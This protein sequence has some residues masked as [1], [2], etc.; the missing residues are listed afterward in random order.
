MSSLER[1]R[2]NLYEVGLASEMQGDMDEFEF[3]DYLAE[4][5]ML[6]I[7]DK[8][9]TVVWYV[10]SDRDCS[11]FAEVKEQDDGTIDF[12]TMHYNGGGSLE[13]VLE[14]YIKRLEEEE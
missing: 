2:G 6:H 10:K 12:H 4:K 5:D 3:C 9:Y 13:E 11:F 7:G 14:P 8:I 1:N